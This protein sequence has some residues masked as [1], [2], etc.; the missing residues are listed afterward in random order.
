M[1]RRSVLSLLILPVSLGYL[2]SGSAFAQDPATSPDFDIPGGHFYKQANGQGGSGES[3][4]AIANDSAAPFWDQFQQLGGV[5]AVGYP[6]STRFNWNGF[7]CQTMQKEVFQWRPDTGRVSFVN[8]FDELTNSGKDDWLLNLRQVPKPFDNSPDTGMSWDAVVQRH[9]AFLDQDRNIRD[10]YFSDTDW[11]DHYGLPQ[12]YADFGDLFVVRTQRAVFQHW[13]TAQPWAKAGDVTIANGG[14]IAKEAGLLPAQALVPQLATGD[15]S[16]QPAPPPIA[17]PQ[18]ASRP[19]IMLITIDSLSSK[20]VGVYGNNRIKTPTIDS[21][22]QKGTRFGQAINV[23]SQTNPSI[24]SIFTSVYPATNGVGVQGQDKLKD[25][26]DTLAGV[27]ASNGYN[28]AAIYSSRSLD[29][30]ISGLNRGFKTYQPVYVPEPGQTDIWRLYQGHANVTTDA[31][32]SWLKQN[33]GGPF[34]LWVHYEDPHYPYTPQ[35]PFDTMYDRCDTCVDGGY[36][37]VDRLTIGAQLSPR[38]VAHLVGL[39]EGEITYT[40]QELGRMLDA[41]GSLGIMDNTMVVLTADEGQS[42]GD[43]GLWFHPDIFYDTVVRAP[44]IISHPPTVPQGKLVDSLTRG[45]DIMPTILE[46]AGVPTPSASEGKSLWPLIRGQEVGNTRVGFIQG[47]FD[48]FITVVTPDWKLI[49][50]NATGQLLLFNLRSD[51]NEFSN[52][53]PS[54]PQK[55]AEME[56]QAKDWMN[57]HGVKY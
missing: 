14:D 37:T 34:F 40:D 36:G 25:S 18:R 53:A 17:Q 24:A 12:S 56:Q 35:P 8:V 13:K 26:V 51:P 10:R 47:L 19:S 48:K 16:G 3:G 33:S 31:V 15:Q 22:A 1:L 21:L 6:A 41:A 29:A 30:E 11:L 49:R 28:T 7:V 50:N 2:F 45:I 39:Y 9:L 55:A 52:Q 27:L 4:Y 44:L 54:N 23:F 38:D 20:H 57:N 32:I 5:D 43:N 46:T 42:L